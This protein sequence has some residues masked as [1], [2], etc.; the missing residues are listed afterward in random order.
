MLCRCIMEQ[1]LTWNDQKK[2]VEACKDTIEPGPTCV[3]E[4]ELL[5]GLE[6]F[7]DIHK[8]NKLPLC[9]DIFDYDDFDDYFDLDNYD[10]VFDNDDPVFDNDDPDFDYD[11]DFDLDNYDSVFDNCDPVFEY[12]D[13]Q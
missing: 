11:D 1:S 13:P 2:V 4:N 10:P 5:F 12:C 9:D 6:H 8:H 7:R 3:K